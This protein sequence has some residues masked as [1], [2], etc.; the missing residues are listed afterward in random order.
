MTRLSFGR[1]LLEGL[2]T[3]A[4]QMTVAAV[5]VVEHFNIIEDIGA[6]YVLGLVDAFTNP[7]FLQNPEKGLSHCIIPAVAA[8]PG[9]IQC[10]FLAQLNLPITL[11][12][13]IHHLNT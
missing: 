4:A 9:L 7:L 11:S 8:I 5:T 12:L 2:G 6:G 3:D 10:V 1:G 13:N